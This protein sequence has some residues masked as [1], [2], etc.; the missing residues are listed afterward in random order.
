M[1]SKFNFNLISHRD[2]RKFFTKKMELERWEFASAFES[3]LAHFSYNTQIAYNFP[4][5]KN[6]K[7]IIK[8]IAKEMQHNFILPFISFTKENMNKVLEQ[9]PHFIDDGVYHFKNSE[10]KK[11]L[12]NYPVKTYEQINKIVN[13]KY[14]KSPNDTSFILEKSV[15]KPMTFKGNNFELRAYL[16]AVRIGK[17]YFTFMYPSLFFN[18]GVDDIDKNTFFNNLEIKDETNGLNELVVN[19]Y[20]LVQKTSIIL[21]NYL[22]FVIQVYDME[23][24]PSS[25]K[26]DKSQMQYNLYGIDISLDENKKPYLLDVVPNPI[27]GFM[28]LSQRVAK[29]KTRMYNDIVDNFIT[30][31]YRNETLNIDVTDFILL[32]DV[33]PNQTYKFFISKKIFD[34]TGDSK[35]DETI[36]YSL[37]GNEYIPPEGEGFI[38]RLLMENKNNLKNDNQFLGSKLDLMPVGDED[39]MPG[40]YLML[41]SGMYSEEYSGAVNLNDF[42]NHKV[43]NERCVFEN[44]GNVEFPQIDETKI[45]DKI[46]EL[47]NN[48]K[49]NSVMDIAQT[50]VPLLGALLIARK[51]YNTVKDRKLSLNPFTKEEK[52]KKIIKEI[53]RNPK[54]NIIPNANTNTNANA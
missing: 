13:S 14:K 42:V 4:H 33:P 7:I 5:S 51:A 23:N 34:E 46:K 54:V 38:E 28:N 52:P 26:K 9:N 48:E 20:K 6:L 27:F 22:K 24:D 21:S 18:F 2:L 25:T 36:E 31:Y 41:K 39:G 53:I 47:V 15:K 32:N 1:V 11:E 37:E 40:D 45:Q 17:K 43:T 8:K 30:H 44:C 10:G 12:Y 16:L 50:T 29:E 49:K 19:I 35:F 3:N